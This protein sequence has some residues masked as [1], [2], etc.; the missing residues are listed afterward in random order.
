MRSKTFILQSDHEK[1]ARRYTGGVKNGLANG[2]G[3][4]TGAYHYVGAFKDGM[5]NG[6]ASIIIAKMNITMVI[7]RM[8]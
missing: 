2:N 1:L 4:A 5:P 3:D 8:G 7:S 6:T